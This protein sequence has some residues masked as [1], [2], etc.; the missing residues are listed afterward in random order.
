MKSQCFKFIARP[1]APLLLLLWGLPAFAGP[2][3][4]DDNSKLVLSIPPAASH[5]DVAIQLLLDTYPPLPREKQRALLAEYAQT[6]STEVA[7]K[8][9][10]HNLRLVYSVFK[11][12]RVT[13]SNAYFTDV[14]QEGIL[15]LQKAIERFDLDWE[16]EFSTLATPIIKRQMLSYFNN[17]IRLVRIKIAPKKQQ[18]FLQLKKELERQGKSVFEERE[19]LAE[20]LKTSTEIIMALD[21]QLRKKE[22]SL[23]EV[24]KLNNPGSSEDLFVDRV[25]TVAIQNTFPLLDDVPIARDPIFKRR[26]REFL[27]KYSPRNRRIFLQLHFSPEHA[28]QTELAQQHG[29]SRQRI[30]QIEVRMAADFKRYLNRFEQ[31]RSRQEKLHTR[32]D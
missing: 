19:R 2:S 5:S 8:L 26:L 11:K 17:K 22:L 25:D 29:V 1:A 31:R 12:Y 23:D 16:T 24:I 32:F 27:S 15:A 13:V 14:F 18:R 6:K 20:E 3:H 28:T 4:C 21:Q 7:H 10:M 9:I 30:Q